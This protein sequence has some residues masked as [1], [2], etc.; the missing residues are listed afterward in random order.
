MEAISI[1]LLSVVVAALA[2]DK[3]RRRYDVAQRDHASTETRAVDKPKTSRSKVAAPRP[4]DLR[5]AK[6]QAGGPS[7]QGSAYIIDGDTIRIQNTQI[8]LYGVDAPEMNHPYGKKA[9]WA[10]HALCKGRVV[11]AEI[12]ERDAYGRTVARCKLDDGRD[13]SAEMVRLG[14]A[15]DWAKFSGGEYRAFELPNVRKR[16]WL[17]DARQK[18]RMQV[19][20]KFEAGQEVQKTRR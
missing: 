9:K 20:Q 5:S 12:L 4:F 1:A 8:R 13:L 11:H 14:L 16:L 19:W 6:P 7:I 2:F 17:A 3:W 15:I 18:G 10:L